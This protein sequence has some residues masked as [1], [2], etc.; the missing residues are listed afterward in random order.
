MNT[1][2]V[3]NRTSYQAKPSRWPV[4]S[5]DEGF[6]S[7]QNHNDSLVFLRY[8][9]NHIKSRV[10]RW[11]EDKANLLG[12]L[13]ST[14]FKDSH[15]NAQDCVNLGA[16]RL[17]PND[18]PPSFIPEAPIMFCKRR[19]YQ[20]LTQLKPKC[21]PTLDVIPRCLYKTSVIFSFVPRDGC[22]LPLLYAINAALQAMP[23]CPT[24]IRFLECV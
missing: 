3:C 1:L 10:L 13:F 8:S 24:C 5:N 20:V 23:C 15:D 14:L 6:L 11:N 7:T 22:A 2:S 19:V 21:S 17:T 4:L 16:L 9:I 12:K 18:W